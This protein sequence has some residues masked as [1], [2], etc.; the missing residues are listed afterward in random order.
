MFK[1]TIDLFMFFFYNIRL[2]RV[3]WFF[4]VIISMCVCGIMIQKVWIRYE[5]RSLIMG[6]DETLTPISAIPLPALTICPSIKSHKKDFDFSK[7]FL[8]IRGSNGPPY[9]LTDSE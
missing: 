1:N 4:A 7:A 3:W 2:V 5:R 6:Y 8:K 9:N